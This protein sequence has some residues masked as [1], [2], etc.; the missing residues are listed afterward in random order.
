MAVYSRT[1]AGARS[2]NGEHLVVQ[3]GNPTKATCSE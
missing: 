2:G 3:L 1:V